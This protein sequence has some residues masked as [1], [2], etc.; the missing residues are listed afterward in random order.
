M[1]TP[2][3]LEQIRRGILHPENEVRV[4]STSYFTSARLGDLAVMPRV[5]EA[6]ET[7]GLAA[8]FSLLREAER[9]PQSPQTLDWVLRPLAQPSDRSNVSSDNLRFAL[10]LIVAAAPLDVVRP[11]R[12]EITRLAD[13]PAELRDPLEERFELETWPFAKTWQALET[14]GRETLKRQDYTLPELR[15]ASR[16][17]E[18]LARHAG[19]QGD[20]IAGYLL[21]DDLERDR[22]LAWL[23]PDLV[24]LAG[25]MGL[26]QTISALVDRLEL[27]EPSLTDSAIDALT[28]LGGDDVITA[29]C[30]R[31]DDA[32]DEF[33]LA[34]VDAAVQ[35]EPEL[36]AGFAGF[37]PAA[38]VPTGG[39]AAN[40][41]TAAL[42]TVSV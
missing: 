23:E 2:L 41:P 4:T 13:F 42:R 31:W 1:K 21:G 9:L 11:R 26:R 8:S 40:D 28:T 20:R 37:E 33:R 38:L 34:A 14:L 3:P 17:I 30:E 36:L 7:Y 29:I 6:I 5:I 10:G 24:R 22:V 39:A 32:D 12:E 18:A 16:L 15:R 19:E 25:A 27:D 35:G